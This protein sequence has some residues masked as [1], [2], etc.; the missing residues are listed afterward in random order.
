VKAR[1]QEREI[2][3]TSSRDFILSQYAQFISNHGKRLEKSLEMAIAG[4]PD[5]DASTWWTII[6]AKREKMIE[7]FR[8]MAIDS[9]PLGADVTIP[10]KMGDRFR[11]D[12]EL[13]IAEPRRS[14]TKQTIESE[15]VCVLQFT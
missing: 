6:S 12:L 13:T 5:A 14:I 4:I 9:L 15:S 7:E 8:Q 1:D 3:V 11:V 10:A 2:L